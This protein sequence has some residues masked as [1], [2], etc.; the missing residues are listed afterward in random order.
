MEEKKPLKIK[1]KTAVIIIV[2]AVVLLGIGANVYATKQGYDNIFFLIKYKISGQKQETITGK[3]N[4]LT[5]R[6]IDTTIKSNTNADIM[7]F[8]EKEV[9]ESFQKYLNL[10]AQRHCDIGG[11][12]Q[13]LNFEMN[14]SKYVPS[15]KLAGYLKT[16]IKY[17]DFKEKV[18]NYVTEKCFEE[19]I[20]NLGEEI[21]D[22]AKAFINEDGYLC[23]CN[24]AATG[25]IYKLEDISKIGNKNYK[26][27]VLYIQEEDKE[28]IEF[29]FG[30]ENVN[31]RCVIDY[32]NKINRKTIEENNSTE[33]SKEN[34]NEIKENII[35]FNGMEI[36]K[37]VGVQDL[38]DMKKNNENMKK[39]NTTYYN[40][41]NGQSKGKT[42]G[43]FGEETYEGVSVVKNVS[44]IAMTKNYNA[45]PRKVETIGALLEELRDLGD[46]SDALVNKVDLDNDGTEEF[47]VCYKQN[48][49]AGDYENGEAR[50]I[51]GITLYDKNLKK[52]SD[53]VVLEN[54]FWG[55]IKDEQ[56]KVFLS[57]NDIEYIDIDEDGIME[58]IIKVP[59]Y[60]GT[61]ISILKYN[62]GT[63]QGVKN[64]KASVAP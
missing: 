52:I 20:N 17:S 1:F 19:N 56:H 12:I 42:N 9:K 10:V 5:D 32:C 13:E 55:N 61:K 26:A 41:E 25:V 34:T 58:I 16:D 37:N 7:P 23:Y 49:R 50:A 29:E 27:N 64:L 15:K 62:K 43:T 40:Y 2:T 4:L 63:L 28:I 54:G 53:L 21:S 33:E 18:L 31:G 47:I 3:D 51:S 14:E 6:D 30:I 35:L 38:V 60:E 22:D 11:V 36:S 59:T 24:G 8:T 44:K 45:I 46:Y 48:E 57:I 39:Y